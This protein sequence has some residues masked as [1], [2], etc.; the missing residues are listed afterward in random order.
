MLQGQAL[1]APAA[2]RK[3]EAKRTMA[4][5]WNAAEAERALLQY[6]RAL[7]DSANVKAHEYLL[8]KRGLDAHTWATFGLVYRHDTPLPGTWNGSTRSYSHP[9]Q[10]AIAIPW[11]RGKQLVAIRYRFLAAHTYIDASGNE[12]TEKQTAAKNSQFTGHL[13]GGQAM[14]YFPPAAGRPDVLQQRTLVI[15]EGEINCMSIWQVANETRLDV[16]SLGS[17]SQHLTTAQVEH[18]Q[19]YKA[20][21]LWADREEIAE[22]LQEVIPSAYVVSSAR[23]LGQD[24]NDLLQAGKLGLYLSTW[25]FDAAKDREAQAALL[26]DLLEVMRAWHRVDDGTKQV[27]QWM[28]EQLQIQVEVT[29][30]GLAP[31]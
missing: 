10:P 29:S 18:A 16:L 13:F 5:E 19:R 8:D 24:A 21:V 4:R 27:A 17:E 22:Q 26:F 25:R 12:R 15:C 1:P 20:V 11:Y 3:P 14:T 9:P 7:W 31:G 2:P 6:Q 28:A 30:D 23:C